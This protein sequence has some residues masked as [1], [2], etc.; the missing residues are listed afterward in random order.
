MSL[1]DYFKGPTHKATAERLQAELNTLRLKSESDFHGL[2]KKHAELES[3]VRDTGA[4]DL[5]SV[6]ARIKVEEGRLSDL[7]SQLAVVTCP[8]FSDHV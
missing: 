8:V 3:K 4:L 7:Q 6:Q 5:F 1:A 2:Q